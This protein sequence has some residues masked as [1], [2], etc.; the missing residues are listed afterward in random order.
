MK[1]ILYFV[2]TKRK[3]PDEC[4]L[5]DLKYLSI[6]LLITVQCSENTNISGIIRL[7]TG[8]IA[9]R[10]WIDWQDAFSAAVRIQSSPKSILTALNCFLSSVVLCVFAVV[11]CSQKNRVMLC[12][13]IISHVGIWGHHM[14]P[15][16]INIL[17]RTPFHPYWHILH[18]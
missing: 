9:T 4:R 16:F 8:L 7:S 1:G 10:L 18:T 17:A 6:L 11:L 3:K 14:C 5:L 2:L 12:V 13:L 15:E